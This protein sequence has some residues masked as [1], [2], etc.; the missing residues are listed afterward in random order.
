MF[1]PKVSI[2]VR[3]KNEKI[4][5]IKCLNEIYNQNY[6]N[7]EVILVDN[8][9]SDGTIKIAKKNFPKLKIVKYK[10]KKFFPGRALNLGI[11]KSSEI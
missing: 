1:A 7:I 6:K 8:N 11:R 10:S 2:I 4:W 3:S 5:I 9:S